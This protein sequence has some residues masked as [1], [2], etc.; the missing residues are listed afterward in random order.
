MLQ[1]SEEEEKTPVPVDIRFDSYYPYAQLTEALHALC[2]AHPDL[3]AIESI[4]KSHEGRDVWLVTATNTKTGPAAE[5]PAFWCDGNIHA[6]E[7]AASAACLYLLYKVA[8][9]YGTRKDVTRLLDT[10]ALYVV[11]RVNPDGS[12]LFFSNKPKLIRSS[13]R[14]YPYNEDPIEGLIEEDI[15]GD[16]RILQMRIQDP[17]GP[18]KVHPEEPRLFTKRDPVEEGGTYYRILPEGRLEDYDGHT[19]TLARDKEGLDLNRNFPAHWRQ[20]H[21]QPGAGP[22]PGSEPEAHNLIKFVTSHPNITGAIAFHTFSGVI[23]RPYGT[24]ADDTFPAEDLWTYQTIGKKG[25]ELTGYPT[26]SVF[27]DFKYHPKEVITGVFDDW[28][29]DH[30]G[31]FAWTVEVW[32]PHRHAGITEGF[33]EKTKPGSFKFMEWFR[34]HPVEDDLKLLRWADAAL[35]GQGFVAWRKF[36]HPQLGEIEIGGWDTQLCFRNPPPKYLEEEIA[37][38][39]DW[40]IWHALLSPRLEL[41]SVTAEA[42]GDGAYLVR[43]I[44]DNAG[45]LPTYVTKK[46]LEKKVV[47]PIVVEIEL[48]AGAKLESGKARAETGQLE[49]RAYKTATPVMWA[50]DPTSE[51]LKAEWVVRGKKGDVLK[52]VARH[53]RAGV[54][55]AEVTL[56]GH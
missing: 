8:T 26:V 1:E 7:V 31:V 2:T 53:E 6:T 17:N 56:P 9:E 15:D 35:P 32:S 46:A 21:E 13:V 5:K 37:P 12:E 22:F 16:G 41:A 51:R 33:D 42:I 48:P 24:H 30:L 11:P 39:A 44:V 29:Y 54:L 34:E 18:W 25:T 40:V 20:E 23:L 38:L 36:E 19:I 49:G 47:R 45:W 55:R 50:A 14:P 27:H 10:R 43:M 52:L 3:L 28:A 4:G